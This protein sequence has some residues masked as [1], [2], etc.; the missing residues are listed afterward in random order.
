MLVARNALKKEQRDQRAATLEAYK[1]K[2]Q[3]QVDVNRSYKDIS[4][5]VSPHKVTKS[6]TKFANLF[7]AI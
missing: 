2:D 6:V 1:A 7:I 5:K 4:T 3:N